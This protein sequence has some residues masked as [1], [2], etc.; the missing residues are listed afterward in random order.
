MTEGGRPLLTPSSSTGTAFPV[1]SFVVA[2]GM[3]SVSNWKAA[4]VLPASVDR[5]IAMRVLHESHA[6]EWSGP[7]ASAKARTMS[8]VD[9][10]TVFGIAS[11]AGMRNSCSVLT[12]QRESTLLSVI[13]SWVQKGGP[14]HSQ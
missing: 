6:A 2:V 10:A 7:R 4:N 1:Q 5:I 9:L 11:S 3:E 8:C 13:K 14:H 12:G